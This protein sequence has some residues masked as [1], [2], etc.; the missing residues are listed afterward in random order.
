MVAVV[1]ATGEE[2]DHAIVSRVLEGETNAYR[3]LVD[4]YQRQ[5]FR[6]GARF[7]RSAE[8]A[9]DYVQEVFLKAFER[10]RQYRRS[11]RF[12]S[13]LMR[14]AFNH[15]M[16]RI[17]KKQLPLLA[18]EIDPPDQRR[19]PE[20]QALRQLAC[21]ELQ[22]AIAELPPPAAACIE[23]FFFF[24]LTHKEVS[25]TT[26]IPVNTVK[27]HVLRAKQRL[28]VRLAGTIAEDYHEL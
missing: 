20:T 9:Q 6:L 13:W 3:L 11:G 17:A 26:G 2:P 7:H 5:V 4:R 23:L 12:Y 24:G 8:D 19:N 16:D 14:I 18:Q 10:L 21:R 22:H 27:S 25:R 15:G 1:S 28:R